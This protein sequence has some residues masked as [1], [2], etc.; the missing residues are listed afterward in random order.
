MG[1][2]RKG[3]LAASFAREKKADAAVGAQQQLVEQRR[4]YEAIIDDLEKKIGARSELL[5]A[6]PS[7]LVELADLR[8]DGE[9][10]PRQAMDLELVQSYADRMIVDDSTGLITDPEG[11]PWPLITVYDDGESR[12]LADGFHRVHAAKQAGLGVLQAH[13]ARGDRRDAILFSF[14]V[15][16]DHG[17]RRTRADTQRIMTRLLSD[18]VW[19]SYT[20]AW[21]AE[22]CKV[23]APTIRSHRKKL[24]QARQIPFCTILR[25]RDGREYEREADVELDDSGFVA[26]PPEPAR[27]RARSNG[28]AKKLSKKT[29]SNRRRA[30]EV[31]DF[32]AL[33]SLEAPLIIASPGSV[34]DYERLACALSSA[35]ELLIIP[36]PVGTT[37]MWRG[38]EALDPLV[39]EYGMDGPHI[40]YITAHQR[41]YHVWTSGEAPSPITADAG[42]ILGSHTPRFVGQPLGGWSRQLE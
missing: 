22:I 7:T 5:E 14:G 2:R 24:E 38:P 17:K 36:A 30:D 23:S 9:T 21:L 3:G 25:S 40:V 35:P 16:A 31:V 33:G 1:S 13:I 28:P 26:A 18:E 41:F 20:D 8:L 15:N 12:W 34:E 32:G 27:Q 10:Q 29:S 39:R 11:T 19:A 37:H 42:D 4:E 6:P